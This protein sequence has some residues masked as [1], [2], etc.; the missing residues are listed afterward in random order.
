MECSNFSDSIYCYFYFSHL[1]NDESRYNYPDFAIC[2]V[3]LVSIIVRKE[4]Q[5]DLLSQTTSRRSN[6]G[7]TEIRI[8]GTGHIVNDKLNIHSPHP[9]PLPQGERISLCLPLSRGELYFPSLDG[10]RRGCIHT[11]FTIV[12]ICPFSCVSF[13]PCFGGF[14]IPFHGVSFETERGSR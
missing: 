7:S 4:I 3:C 10:G 13:L 5:V 9:S 11:S 1:R 8:H 12:F 2:I 6:H 14:C